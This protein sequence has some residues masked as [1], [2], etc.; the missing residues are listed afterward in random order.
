MPSE[1]ALLPGVAQG[2]PAG[3]VWSSSRM[4]ELSRQP[5]QLPD[6]PRRSR[7]AYCGVC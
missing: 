5:M 2:T 6:R 3:R 7:L 4:K 1:A